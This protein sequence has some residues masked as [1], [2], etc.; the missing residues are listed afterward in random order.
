MLVEPRYRSR[1]IFTKKRFKNEKYSSI[2]S[3]LKS[4]TNKNIALDYSQLRIACFH[5]LLSSLSKGSVIA[6]SSYTIYDMI[7]VIISAGHKPFLVDIDSETLC[8]SLDSL[9]DLARAKK[10]HGLIFTHLHGYNVNLKELA[11]VCQKNN[12]LLIEDCAQSLWS[13]NFVNDADL[14]G[15]YGD[16]A[17]FSSGLFKN[18]N[19]ISGGYLLLNS[20]NS[21]FSTVINEHK[22][23]PNNIQRDFISRSLYALFFKFL[24][25]RLIFSNFLFPILKI[26]KRFDIDF[27]NKRAR[28]E[29]N[30]TYIKRTFKDI[31]RMNFIQKYLINQKSIYSLNSDHEKRYLNAEIYLN[32]LKRLLNNNTISI[33]GYKSNTEIDN[34]KNLSSFPQIPLMCKNLNELLIYL[35]DKNVDI[36][37]QHIKN[38]SEFQIYNKSGFK[39]E[40]A[41]KISRK[42]LLLPT[43]PEYTKKSIKRICHLINSFY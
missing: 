23:L 28:E 36:G 13:S 38:L 4:L 25:S 26:S 15:S 35:I 1:P 34:Y 12:I 5:L 7:N 18:I 2:E 6:T 19:T 43:Y 41:K 30:P 11:E 16:A 21:K 42:V 14:P 9:L 22:N 37:Q 31:K 39:C 29:N 27:I 8:P 3:Y 40:N 24:T 33:P 10:V 32:N 17:L 20:K